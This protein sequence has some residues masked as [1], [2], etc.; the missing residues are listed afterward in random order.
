MKKFY[1]VLAYI[2]PYSAYAG[3]NVFFNLLT[4]VFSLFSFALLIPFLNLLF[5]INELVTEKPEF[6]LSTDS[7]L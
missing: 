2:K 7:N 1:R 6:S 4:V 5:G 3:L